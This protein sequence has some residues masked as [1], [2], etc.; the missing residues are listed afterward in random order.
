MRLI[1][2]IFVRLKQSKFVF[3]SFQVLFG[4]V[5]LLPKKKDLIIFESFLGKQYSDSPR[6]IYEYLMAHNKDFDM[7]WSV[8]KHSVKKFKQYGVP[9]LR[10]LSFRWFLTVPR[11]SYWVSNSRFPSW[12]RKG[13]GTTYLQT[14]HGTPLKK[15]G[16]D[17]N[18]VKM[19]QINTKQ[20]RQSFIQEAE[21]WDYLISPNSYSTEIFKRAFGFNGE[22]IESGYPRNDQLFIRNKP[23][24][25]RELKQKMDIPSDKKV[26]LYAPTW[27]DNQHLPTGGYRLELELDLERMQAELGDKYVVL[28]RLHYLI[29][30]RIDISKYEGFAY[31]MSNYDDIGDLYLISDMLIT[32]YSSVFFDYAILNRP[33]LFYVYDIEDYREDIRGFYFELENEAPGPLLLSTDAVIETIF[34]IDKGVYKVDEKYARFQSRFTKWEDGKATSRVVKK[35]FNV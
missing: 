2:K 32:D 26:I 33:I 24:V 31:N 21:K 8:N 11:A 27:R 9:H 3:F 4:L 30:E 15:L 14:W 5:S 6:A 25:I 29:S 18:E 35:V 20:Y 23:E 12:M 10:R 1:Y 13:K 28:L 19:Y 7:I 17:I 34:E 16:I 22:M